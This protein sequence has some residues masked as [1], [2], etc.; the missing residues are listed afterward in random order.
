[1]KRKVSY[2]PRPLHSVWCILAVVFFLVEKNILL[3]RKQTVLESAEIYRASA[4]QALCK[5]AF[6]TAG[7]F[8]SPPFRCEISLS[9]A[10]LLFGV[11]RKVQI[12]DESVRT[13]GCP[14]ESKNPLTSQSRGRTTRAISC[15]FLLRASDIRC[16][17]LTTTSLLKPFP[18]IFLDRV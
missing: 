3:I 10:G 14:Y 16:P 13:R 4:V 1:M 11:S 12:S 15:R 6:F 9:D 17:P 5:A 18:R 7:L 8:F 2:A